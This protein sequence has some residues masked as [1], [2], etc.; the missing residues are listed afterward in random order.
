MLSLYII[1]FLILWTYVSFNWYSW[2]TSIDLRRMKRVD[3]TEIKKSYKSFEEMEK[4]LNKKDVWYKELWFWFFVYTERFF[5]IPKDIY[6]FFKKGIQRWGRGWADEDVWS[7]DYF[8]EEI[9]PPM[10]RRLKK[11][12]CGVPIVVG[13]ME[14]DEAYVEAEK[15]WNEI[16]DTI[17]YTFEIA[18]KIEDLEWFYVENEKDRNQQRKIMNSLNVKREKRKVELAHLMTRKE[19]RKYR[20]GWKYFQQHFFS[21]C[22]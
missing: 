22:D 19:C 12:K 21:L 20:R 18:R 11:T 15:Q 2:K 1:L 3:K 14:T 17:I 7:I 4:S 9:I 8:L 16:L 13:K 6:R 10:L 5:D